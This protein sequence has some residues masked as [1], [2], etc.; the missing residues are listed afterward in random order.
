MIP[1]Q[2]GKRHPQL[3]AAELRS[4]NQTMNTGASLNIPLTP[5]LERFVEQRIASGLNHSAEDVVR[6]ALLALE[7]SERDAEQ[8]FAQLKNKLQN[9]SSQ[10][11]L[12]GAAD[13]E[14]YMAGLLSRLQKRRETPGAA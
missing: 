12:E 10:E 11:Q 13:G 5:E 4:D 14:T 7:S 2:S 9:A 3:T 8:A 1:S 6:E